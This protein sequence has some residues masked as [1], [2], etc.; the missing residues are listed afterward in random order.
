M[1]DPVVL[2]ILLK[3]PD[4]QEIDLKE[5]QLRLLVGL[6]SAYC[7]I[8]LKKPNFRVCPSVLFLCETTPALNYDVM[9]V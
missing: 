6:L 5:L 1:K 7:Y 9:A 4:I 8:V 3:M 2:L